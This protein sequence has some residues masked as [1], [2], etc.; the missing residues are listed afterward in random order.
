[1][2]KLFLAVFLLSFALLQGAEELILVEKVFRN[3]KSLSEKN[4]FVPHS[5]RQWNCSML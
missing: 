5:L 1:M 3:V 2:K 4:R